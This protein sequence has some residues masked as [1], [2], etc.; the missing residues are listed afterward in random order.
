MEYLQ[1]AADNFIIE[2]CVPIW[3]SPE[4]IPQKFCSEEGSGGECVEEIESEWSIVYL[5]SNAYLF[6]EFILSWAAKK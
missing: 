6:S 1:H 2:V 4:K 5:F 3:Q